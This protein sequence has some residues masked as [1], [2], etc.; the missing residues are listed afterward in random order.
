VNDF[1]THLAT[2]DIK[3][4]LEGGRL[5]V[6]APPGVLTPAL[7]EQLS[8]RKEE[9]LALLHDQAALRPI[10]R[11]ATT[12]TRRQGD[13]ETGRQAC[14]LALA[15]LVI[16]SSCLLVILSSERVAL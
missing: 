6:N 13:K 7:R 2:L 11:R 8:A 15:H 5:T 9:L 10:P 4:K 3:L 16:S 14:L 12:E 1:L